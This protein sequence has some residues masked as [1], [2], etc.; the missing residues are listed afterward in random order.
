MTS[1]LAAL[2]AE[3]PDAVIVGDEAYATV[4][5]GAISLIQG[6]EEVHAVRYRLTVDAIVSAPTAEEALRML[7]ETPCST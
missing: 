1:L 5:D 4:S 7:R 2:Q 6:T 3:Y